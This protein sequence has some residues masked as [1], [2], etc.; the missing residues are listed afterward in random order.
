MGRYT[1]N[2]ERCIFRGNRRVTEKKGV[3]GAA[4]SNE[5]QGKGCSRST[6]QMKWW[7]IRH[8]ERAAGSARDRNKESETREEMQN[9]THWIWIK[10]QQGYG[11]GGRSVSFLLS[12][13]AEMTFVA[14]DK[15][16]YS[17]S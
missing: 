15:E 16:N 4:N 17:R 9:G 3:E 12:S 14:R 2:V 6:P 1:R 10:Q 13:M 8:L 5:P 11:R 7:R